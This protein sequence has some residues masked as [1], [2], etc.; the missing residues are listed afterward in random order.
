M[1]SFQRQSSAISNAS[2]SSFMDN[3]V[4]LSISTLRQLIINNIEYFQKLRS[5]TGEKFYTLFCVIEQEADAMRPTVEALERISHNFDFDPKVPGN[6]YRSLVQVVDACVD[7]LIKV[8]RSISQTRESY[9][10]RSG[11]HLKELESYG[12]VL[13]QLRV[14][15]GYAQKLVAYSE[16]GN[17]FPNNDEQFPENVM[18]E[19]QALDRECFYGRCL[20]FQFCESLWQP[21]QTVAVALASY[22]E[23][24]QKYEGPF[25]RVASSFFHSGRYLTNP[26]ARGKQILDITNKSDIRFC[27][28]FWSITEG[29]V[30]AEMCNLMAGSVAVNKLI[31]IQP[32]NFEM[33]RSDGEGE[34]ATITPPCAHTGPAPV[35]IRLLCFVEREGQGWLNEAEEIAFQQMG[36]SSKKAK[37]KI[38]KPPSPM[39][40]GLLIHIHGGGF[41]A[42][43]SKSHEIYLRSW[44]K[45]LGVPIV[46]IDYSLAPEQPFPRAFEECFFAYAW[47]V[48]NAPY[49]GSTGE[50]ICLAGDSSG[51]NLCTAVAMR[52]AS[53]GIQVPD[54]I[55]TMY[56]PFAV[57]HSAS[58][59]RL[60]CLLDPLLPFGVL[61]RCLSAY[62][63]LK[64][65]FMTEEKVTS[66]VDNA[67][68]RILGSP[69]RS[70]MKSGEGSPVVGEKEEK[71]EEEE[72]GNSTKVTTPTTTKEGVNG[73]IIVPPPSDSVSSFMEEVPPTD[74]EKLE[75]VSDAIDNATIGQGDGQTD[76]NGEQ[77]SPEAI[78]IFDPSHP[79]NTADHPN[80][81]PADIDAISLDSKPEADREEEDEE[82]SVPLSPKSRED[83]HLDLKEEGLAGDEEVQ[84]PT[85]FVNSPI[86][87][88]KD[89]PIMRNP[90][91][92]P[93]FSDEE[94]LKGLPPVHIIGCA[95]DP[96]LDDSISFAKK[97]RGMGKPVFLEIVNQLPHG[98]LNFSTVGKECKEA[99]MVCV[100]HIMHVLYGFQDNDF[101]N[102]GD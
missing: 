42:H 59:S 31:Q 15:L 79:P 56:T 32:H 24:Y 1:A 19:V 76:T 99:S 44:A 18:L 63:D 17:L 81:L 95:L 21:L 90:Y 61:M 36:K 87:V 10:F 68:D 14:I 47:A 12:A 2:S 67:N 83:L 69:K 46:S 40:K 75:Q 22:A 89:A 39:S 45:D 70:S 26:E 13:G 33:E 9:L 78:A 77:S 72:N 92:S 86:R 101:E 98:F 23:G 96:L 74:I 100:R 58:P 91:V 29:D 54:G 37:Q 30:I 27:K 34:T 85:S 11:F 53:Y 62:V 6:G 94:L 16:P 51:G 82:D 97:L 64:E 28:A 65:E 49:L 93:L 3:S 25:S 43:T 52:A 20:G 48:K 71:I 55:V 88:F 38:E 84:T 66:M 73:D 4:L 7:R 57:H 80:S 8:V 60:L 5:S 102:L 35:Q 50:H 41:V